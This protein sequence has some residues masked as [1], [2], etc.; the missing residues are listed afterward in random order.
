MGVFHKAWLQG[1]SISNA[2]GC[3]RATEVYPV[4]RRVPLSQL[5]QDTSSSPT[6]SAPTPYAPFCTPR[7][8]GAT[9]VNPPCTEPP[10]PL[11]L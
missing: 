1:M 11:P 5:P 3:F 2:T 7:K 10:Q 4:D 9:D 8:E 6:R